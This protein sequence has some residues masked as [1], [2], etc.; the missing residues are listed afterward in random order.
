[1]ASYPRQA[2]GRDRPGCLYHK[3]NDEF[4]KKQM[5]LVCFKLSNVYMCQ[6]IT[7]NSASKNKFYVLLCPWPTSQYCARSLRS[8]EDLRRQ[9][10]MLNNM[11]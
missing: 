7:S 1:M 11:S 2:K 4:L 6:S 10:S 8:H 9:A 5:C 3:E